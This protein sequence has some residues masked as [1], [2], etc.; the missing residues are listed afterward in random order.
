[1]KLQHRLCAK[2]RLG[3]QLHELLT[4][5]ARLQ[6]VEDLSKPFVTDI[7]QGFGRQL[8]IRCRAASL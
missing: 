7:G 3:E 6:F 4:I 1:M 2:Q 8:S 5:A